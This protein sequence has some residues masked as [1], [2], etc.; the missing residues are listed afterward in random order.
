MI[1]YI[2][3]KEQGTKEKENERITFDVQERKIQR[4]H[5]GI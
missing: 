1:L 4:E 5:T 2:Q 3:I